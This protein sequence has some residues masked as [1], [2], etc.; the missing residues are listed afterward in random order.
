MVGSITCTRHGS[1]TAYRK[2]LEN[3][4]VVI[5]GASGFIGTG[6]VAQ[7]RGE[8]HEV[9]RLVRRTTLAPDELSWTP[10]ERTLGAD[11]LVG[12]DAVVNLAGV[13][14]GDHRWTPSYKRQIQR[15][16]VDATTT[17]AHAVAAGI[18][19]GGPRVLVNASAIGYYGDRDDELLDED[20][21]AGDGFLPDVCRAW[22][23]STQAAEEA[24]A[25]VAVVRTGLVLGPKG[26][27][28]GRLVPLFSAGVG[29]RLGSGKQWMS[30]ISLADEVSAIRFLLDHDV[31]GPVNATGPKPVR[32]DEFTQVIGEL[33]KR[34]TLLPVPKVGLRIVL[35][36][37]S[38]DVLS[39]ANVI[40]TALMDAGFV[41]AHPD[42]T[43]ALR[44]A[45][46]R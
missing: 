26:G 38:S 13:G 43:S 4:R 32:N 33:L 37:F 27:L 35:G 10:A 25:R 21:P 15:S 23:G 12:A 41:H 45:L 6:L 22:E 16:R 1:V 3:M 44:W 34:P 19:D 11:A 30:W 40:P 2:G 5:A 7:L 24:G 18:G 14:I 31:A 46:D 36:E 42:V 29:G 28:L 8:G 39:S 20:S 17:L 9:V